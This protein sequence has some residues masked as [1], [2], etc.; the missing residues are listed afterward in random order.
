MTNGHEIDHWVEW[1]HKGWWVNMDHS[2][3]NHAVFQLPNQ[4][5]KQISMHHASEISHVFG[6]PDSLPPPVHLR[7]LKI[8]N[9]NTQERA[10]LL[11]IIH[12]MCFPHQRQFTFSSAEK[13]NYRRISRA[14][15]CEKWLCADYSTS[16]EATALVL[17]RELSMENWPRLRFSFDKHNIQQSELMTPNESIHPG[18]LNALWESALWNL[19][20]YG[21]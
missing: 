7:I 17:L 10:S 13:I 5:I 1:W 21:N 18:R 6:V 15:R 20:Q 12:E 19:P 16:G 3:K 11:H 14:L 9:L 2:W 4:A 8:I